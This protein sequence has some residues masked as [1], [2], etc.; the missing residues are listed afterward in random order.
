MTLCL[1]Q[2]ALSL[3]KVHKA[4]PGVRAA[5]NL[6]QT[7]VTHYL[8]MAIKILAR[9]DLSTTGLSTHLSTTITA[10]A[11][12]AGISTPTRS[13]T[14]GHDVAETQNQLDLQTILGAD[15]RFGQPVQN[16]TS[17]SYR[18]MPGSQDELLALLG[19]FDEDQQEG[20]INP[21]GQVADFSW[22]L[23]DMWNP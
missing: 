14:E 17:D 18:D 6:E 21:S 1:S 11:R 13:V 23:G 8:T 3:I 4:P 20:S 16:H 5:V 10:I 2:A 19:I 7:V 22:L 15:T 12:V 9:S